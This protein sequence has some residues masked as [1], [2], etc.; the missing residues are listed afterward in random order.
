MMM[1]TLKITKHK[2]FMKQVSPQRMKIP[3]RVRRIANPPHIFISGHEGTQRKVLW[4]T[5][6][7]SR[8]ASRISQPAQRHAI[9][10]TQYAVRNT[11]PITN[12]QLLIIAFSFLLAACS[13]QASSLTSLPQPTSAA[14]EAFIA[15]TNGQA[16]LLS[17]EENGYAH[18]FLYAT[19]GHPLLRLTSGEWDDTDPALSPDGQQLAFASNR[20]GVWDLY[21]LTL[22]TGETRQVTDTPEYDSSPTWSPDSLWLA[23]ETYDG[24]DLEVGILSLADLAQ[25]PVPLTDDPA[26]DF[27]PAWSPQGRQIAF[28]SDRGGNPDVW[29]ADLNRPDEGRYTNLSNSTQSAERRPLWNGS[30]LLWIADAQ[31]LGF[32][33]AY[34]WDSAQPEHPA[35][36]IADADWAA[37]DPT[38]TGTRLATIIRGPNVDYL[39]ASSL[40]SGLLLPPV[41]LPGLVR[42]LLWLTLDLPDPLPESYRVAASFTPV[43]PW[44]AEVTPLAEGPVQRW[45]VIPL[46][47]V[48][49]PYPQLHDLVDE[50]FAGLRARVIHE[51]GWDALASLQNAFVPLTAPLDPGLGDDWLYTGRAFAL[52]S[53]V[54]TAGWMVAV[55]EDIGQQT[56]WRVY[57]RAATQ[58]GSQ[59][60]PLHNAPW[61]LNARYALDP[62]AYE[63][64][65]A[66]APIP[67]GYWVDFTSLARAY[68][69]ERLPALPSWRAYY[70]GTRFTEFVLT[71]NLDWYTAMLELYPAEA[72]VTPT[73]R[74]PPTATPSRTPR[75]TS[76]SGPSPTPSLTPTPTLTPLPSS[77]PTPIP[78]TTPVPSNTPL[79]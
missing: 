65:G 51:A 13:S 19:D 24:S 20:T 25:P 49:A 73:P 54:S 70:G 47:D 44:V 64:G 7:I 40:T 2:V 77:T 50:S 14:T 18:L 34:I 42:G 76:T 69:W 53:L 58:D 1:K 46:P 38:S 75:P 26:A 36:W 59:G 78:T 27:S 57:L 61:D 52:N 45:A 11:Q 37:W 33:G 4:F 15:S 16:I 8:L 60:E 79:P 71:G 66:Y 35:R 6:F 63:R 43:A 17:M 55:R 56:Y 68:D 10:N 41:P 67:S 5:S 22:A 29:L 3:W 23:F 74:L 39:S 12:Y 9:R 30:Q 48:Q 28:L 72:L 21:L 32:S 62:L 31:D